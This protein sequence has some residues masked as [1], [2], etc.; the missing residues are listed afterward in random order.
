[1]NTIN[2]PTATPDEIR[3]G[4]ETWL[5]TT[6]PPSLLGDLEDATADTTVGAFLTTMSG[7]DDDPAELLYA[8][9]LSA[10]G[11]GTCALPF[12]NGEVRLINFPTADPDD[13]ISWEDSDHADGQITLVCYHYAAATDRETTIPLPPAPLDAAPLTAALTTNG[14]PWGALDALRDAVTGILLHLH[15][16]RDLLPTA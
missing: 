16:H 9:V 2:L 12:D 4:V 7:L 8:A 6:L 14:D 1:M 5:T 11:Y 3:A 13:A 15:T 10:I